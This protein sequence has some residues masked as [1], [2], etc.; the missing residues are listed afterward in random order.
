M[1]RRPT[2]GS[3]ALYGDRKDCNLKRALQALIALILALVAAAAAAWMISS[4]DNADE[5][6]S[7]PATA[8]FSASLSATETSS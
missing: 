6:G 2:K 7:E 3:F 8:Q 5:V 1:F 4:R